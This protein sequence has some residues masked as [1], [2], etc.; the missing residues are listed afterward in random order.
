MKINIFLIILTFGLSVNAFSQKASIEFTFTA[1]NNTQYVLLDSIYVENLT[2]GGDTTLYAPDTVLSF[3][4][5]LGVNEIDLSENTFSISQNYPNPFKV[6]TEVNLYLPKKEYIKITVRDI[7]GRELAQ[8]NNTLNRGNHSFAFYAGNE[9]YY[10]LTLIGKQSSETIKMLNT[11]CNTKFAGKCKIVYNEHNDYVVD[12]QSHKAINN[13]VFNIGD[14]LKYNAYSDIL[15]KSIIDT[16]TGNQTYTFQYSVGIPCPETPTVTDIDGNLYN[17]VLIGSQC[18][19]A[20]NLKTTTYSNNTL[21]P[22]VTENSNWQNLTTGAY[23]WYDNDISWKN[24][25]GALYNWYAVNDP[26]GLCPT[27]WHVPEHDEWTALTDF[28]GGTSSPHGNELKSCRQVNSPLGG[29][30]T[31]NEHPRWSQHVTHY[32]TDN[33]GFSG[34]PGGNRNYNGNCAFIGSLGLWWSSTENSSTNAGLRNLFYNFGNVNVYN[35]VKQNGF[36]VRCLRD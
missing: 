19:L 29:G 5:N 26:N 11:N 1:V 13:F 20:E 24:L 35:Y 15:E 33:Y 25:Y 21:I 34:L 22:N 30:C 6:K 8:Y 9:K 17:T 27:G 12:F 10:L 4:Y 36:S 3:E 28:I 23:V 31:T 14:E 18:W 16:P 32:G 7:L 2:Q